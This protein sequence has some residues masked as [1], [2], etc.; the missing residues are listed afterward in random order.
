MHERGP[1]G[2]IEW[3]KS[4]CANTHISRQSQKGMLNDLKGKKKEKEKKR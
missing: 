4:V 1:I 3:H 2:I